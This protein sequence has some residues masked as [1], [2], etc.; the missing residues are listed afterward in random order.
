MHCHL[1]CFPSSRSMF[2]LLSALRV[3]KQTLSWAERGV[4]RNAHC[5]P[6]CRTSHPLVHACKTSRFTPKT[7]N[8]AAGSRDPGRQ[9]SFR[10]LSRGRGAAARQPWTTAVEAP[11]LAAGRS[12]PCATARICSG[13]AA[14]SAAR[15]VA[16]RV[17]CVRTHIPVSD[18]LKAQLAIR[19]SSQQSCSVLRQGMLWR[20][21]ANSD[22]QSSVS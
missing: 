3:C 8:N 17:R 13:T 6:A 1:L 18:L 10:I 22:L 21:D 16:A 4:M 15:C 20:K 14:A 7:A 9:L 19:T 12:A 5:G 2:Q 11:R